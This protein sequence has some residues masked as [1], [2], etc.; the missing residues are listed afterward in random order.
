[1]KPWIKWTLA[2]LAVAVLVGGTLRTLSARQ[3]RQA[4]LEAQQVAQKSQVS[5][6]LAASD[7]VQVK[8]LELQQTVLISGPIKAVHTALVKARIPG[9]LQDLTVREGD[10]VRAGQVLARIDP[11]E[12]EARLRQA[13]QQAAAAKAQV[14]MAQRT[15]DNNQA[16]V[17]QGFISSTALA[18][19]QASLDAAQASY[20]AAQS[21][22]DLA[23]KALD[24][25]V[26]RAPIAGQISQRLAQPGERVPVDA[27]IVEIVDNRQLELEASL[28]AAD[29]LQVKVGQSAQLTLDGTH[30]VIQAKVVRINPSASVGSRTVLV[31]LALAQ[32][33]NLRHGLF[34][35]GSLNVGAVTTLALPLSAVRTDKPQAYVQ[36]VNQNQVQHAN[37]TLGVR[38]NLADLTMVAVTGVAEGS[39]V[40]DGAVGSLRVG[41]LV[42]STQGPQ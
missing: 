14:A 42:T 8:T 26:L 37:V 13:R 31:Y 15:F 40:I 27:R 25:T 29:S 16:L 23:A 22:A 1:M 24:D 34:A 28:N 5:V 30:Q 39:V 21:G 9:E 19:S 32:D 2:G 3:A 33:A 18:S 7:L 41:T 10:S 20:Q 38:G 35:Q 6:A 12:S 11:T 36:L 17:A 4:A